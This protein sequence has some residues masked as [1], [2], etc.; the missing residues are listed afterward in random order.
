MT[1]SNT[2]SLLPAS[3][4][5]AHLNSYGYGYAATAFSMQT[6]SRQTHE[7]YL[8]TVLVYSV[9]K[10]TLLERHSMAP[11]L[12]RALQNHELS[13]YSSLSMDIGLDDLSLHLP[14]PD[15]HPSKVRTLSRGVL[16]N[17]L[18]AYLSAYAPTEKSTGRPDA[19]ERIIRILSAQDPSKVTTFEVT[20]VASSLLLPSG[21][22]LLDHAI[23]AVSSQPAWNK[24]SSV[25][26]KFT[27]MRVPSPDALPE[28]KEIVLGNATEAE[29]EA[30]IDWVCQ[31]HEETKREYGFCLPAL[32][33]EE[34]Q[35]VFPTSTTWDTVRENLLLGDSGTMEGTL[36]NSG[37]EGAPRFKFPVLLMYGGV[38]W[39]L[40]IR[41]PVTYSGPRSNRKVQIR[42]IYD[43]ADKLER[44][45]NR[46]LPA[47]GTG[48]QEDIPKFIAAVNAL[49]LSGDGQ[50]HTAPFSGILLDH[51]AKLSGVSHSQCSLLTIVYLTL[52]GILAKEWQCSVADHRWGEPLRSLDKGLKAYLAGDIQQ[53]SA[54]AS[55]LAII[56]VNHILPDA[57]FI[58]TSLQID[59][60]DLI[61]L[62]VEKVIQIDLPF[63][64]AT[65]SSPSSNPAD[66][67]G[68]LIAR[69]GVS[70]DDLIS[71]CP[72]WPTIT[73]GGPKSLELTHVYASNI[74]D[75]LRARYPAQLPESVEEGGT[76]P[77]GQSEP[78][79]MEQPGGRPAQAGIT[80]PLCQGV[81]PGADAFKLHVQ[82]CR[83]AAAPDGI[84]AANI[85][86]GQIPRHP[87]LAKNSHSYFDQ[88]PE[89]L[90]VAKLNSAF[91]DLKVLRKQVIAEYIARD[92]DRA[93]RLL[94]LLEAD[95]DMTFGSVAFHKNVSLD[96][97]RALR[98]FLREKGCLRTPAPG[99][100]DP[101]DRI[102]PGDRAANNTI[103]MHQISTNLKAR[104]ARQQ[105]HLN[106][107]ARPTGI[108]APV[109]AEPVMPVAR[110]VR[111]FGQGTSK[112]ARQLRRKR[113]LAASGVG[114]DA[115]QPAPAGVQPT[116]ATTQPTPA[117][118]QLQ[119]DSR[120]TP[121]SDQQRSRQQQRSRS[122]QHARRPHHS[123]S[124]SAHHR[125]E[126]RH[127]DYARQR[128][129]YGRNDGCEYFMESHYEETEEYYWTDDQSRREVENPRSVHF[130][131]VQPQPAL[132]QDHERMVTQIHQASL[133]NPFPSWDGDEPTITSSLEVT[134][135]PRAE[136]P[137]PPPGPGW[138]ELIE[139]E[140]RTTPSRSVRFAEDL[141]TVL[142][143]SDS[144]STDMTDVSDSSIPVKPPALIAPP[145][146]VPKP[147]MKAREFR[148]TTKQRRT[149]S[150]YASD[151]DKTVVRE[152]PLD[153]EVTKDSIS[154][155]LQMKGWL[156][157][158]AINYYGK[159]ITD[160]SRAFGRGEVFVFNT[161]F[162]A[163]LASRSYEWLKANTSDQWED[164]FKYEICLFPIHINGNHWAL[165]TIQHRV[166]H[167]GFYC[168]RGESTTFKEK[169][170]DFLKREHLARKGTS[171]PQD[172]RLSDVSRIPLQ[173]P[174]RKLDPTLDPKQ[175]NTWDCGVYTCMYMEYLSRDAPF[176]FSQRDIIN[177]REQ[178]AWEII[179][180]GLVTALDSPRSSLS[181]STSCRRK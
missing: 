124:R 160:R 173:E 169:L 106:D 144:D 51:L 143:E 37:N 16:T 82:S 155:L 86:V 53:V 95:P 48:V 26:K 171:L 98:I 130:S 172:Y 55:V 2:D 45:L 100:I 87:D 5:E 179:S 97:V 104:Q 9:S 142:G 140:M 101:Y 114:N 151:K 91:K 7:S 129:R 92:T 31:K 12:S 175:E 3:Q 41:L 158:D 60:L 154:R 127:H 77:H 131:W 181:G 62:W 84:P 162:T 65:I 4:V 78:N 105:A 156:D 170:L 72:S 63:I 136:T 150:S 157:A 135:Q 29:Y 112:R 107:M 120:L 19:N 94:E 152:A 161:Y 165:A 52:G 17:Q 10:S 93:V 115:A 70:N 110:V 21:I 8:D 134:I 125:N 30:A 6:L 73:S 43:C 153:I 147:T 64:A 141:V 80:C 149:A 44:L 116:P 76:W 117:A 32:D 103:L 85:M 145:V 15:D 126:Q 113:E 33:V 39:Q 1:D 66:N 138:E 111:P 34:L 168:S 36:P 96:I 139:P 68:E 11:Q 75:L 69:V 128:D 122:S 50:V 102:H 133:P 180:G 71:S 74:F 40:H 89:S 47:V 20:G 177:F 24:T 13:A 108:P 35:I 178:I 81:C 88:E 90:T 119:P 25:L 23:A 166:K 83:G 27:K 121:Q 118:L 57:Q 79:S 123:R 174:L 14:S 46:F 67:R 18:Q 167:I 146:P 54:A 58:Q 176:R 42:G 59:P 109:I 56:W 132:I 28:F 38:G 49:D 164:I 137:P 159:L 61:A 148:L 99:W 163:R 22:P